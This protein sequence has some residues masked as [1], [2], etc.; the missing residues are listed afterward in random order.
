MS[1]F[2]FKAA[3]AFLPLLSGVFL[4]YFTFGTFGKFLNLFWGTIYGFG[5]FV[6]NFVFSVRSPTN[7]ILGA[8]VW[9][10]LLSGLFFW[11]SGKLWQ[12]SG[13]IG[14]LV[15]AGLLVA[16]L[17]IVITMSKAYQPPFNSWPTYYNLLFVEW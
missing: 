7:F 10:I 12:Q 5:F 11:L 6:G 4:P 15:E 14:R 2:V 3:F 13:P 16:S 8:Y 1:K 17:F 9:P